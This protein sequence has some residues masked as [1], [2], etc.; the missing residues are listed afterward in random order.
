MSGILFSLEDAI[1][2][3]AQAH[4]NQKDK[5]GAPYILHPLRVM[6]GMTD[7]HGMMTGVLHDVIEDTRFTLEGLRGKGCPED[8]L[9]ALDCLTRRPEESRYEDFI[10]RIIDSKNH[11]ARQVKIAD[12]KDN[13]S[14]ERTQYL[15]EENRL[16]LKNK[17]LPAL[18]AIQ[19]GY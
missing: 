16:R 15:D 4:K 5:G 18:R 17:Y 19:Y 2:L 11:I 1:A 9:N 13:M 14:P 6:H 8:V 3:A 7:M 10:Q 12:I